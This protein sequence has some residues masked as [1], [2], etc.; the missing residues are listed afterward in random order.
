M[1][2]THHGVFFN[3]TFPFCWR[4]LSKPR[5]PEKQ[6]AYDMIYFPSNTALLNTCVWTRKTQ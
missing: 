5:Y 2:F 3:A 6:R 4:I 1:S